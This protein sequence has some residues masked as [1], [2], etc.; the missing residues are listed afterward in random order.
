MRRGEEER[1]SG[2]VLADHVAGLHADELDD[3]V[4]AE[5]GDAPLHGRAAGTVPDHGRTQLDLVGRAPQDVEHRYGAL[6]PGE[7]HDAEHLRRPPVGR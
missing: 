5:P 2:Q 7:P 1:R 6:D 3:V 4:Q